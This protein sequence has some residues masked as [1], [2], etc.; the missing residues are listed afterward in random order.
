MSKTIAY[1]LLKWVL[2]Q[3]RFYQLRH[4]QVLCV[5]CTYH[6]TS[7]NDYFGFSI[8]N[9]FIKPL[10]QVNIARVLVVLCIVACGIDLSCIDWFLLCSDRNSVATFLVLQLDIRSEYTNKVCVWG[11]WWW[12][13][14]SEFV[15]LRR[16][17]DFSDGLIDL[18]KIYGL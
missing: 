8:L 17:Y 13:I 14:V 4:Y 18:L 1:F 15:K 16:L 9:G 3:P 6:P 2:V 11:C 7:V 5:N 10:Q 12:Q